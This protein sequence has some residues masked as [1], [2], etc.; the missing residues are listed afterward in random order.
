MNEAPYYVDFEDQEIE[1]PF[2]DNF[3]LATGEPS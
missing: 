3:T 2:G 1:V